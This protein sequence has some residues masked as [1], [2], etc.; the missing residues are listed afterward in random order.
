MLKKE[1]ME[2]ADIYNKEHYLLDEA[3]K[4]N[5]KHES[6]KKTKKIYPVV[7][8]LILIAL[9][10]A[11]ISL[12]ATTANLIGCIICGILVIVY[13]LL[14]LIESKVR[15]TSSSKWIYLSVTIL[16]LFNLILRLF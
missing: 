5:T 7:A 10:I 4:R 14:F 16:W 2:N 1:I 11:L 6:K 12:F 8:S 15:T 3:R 13:L 9:V